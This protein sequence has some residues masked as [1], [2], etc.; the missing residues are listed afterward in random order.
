[1]SRWKPLRDGLDPLVVQFV[2]E[3]RRMK[4]ASGL[5]LT[6][7]A[8]K[9][10]RSA[11]SWERY[12]DSRVI[13]PLD[14]VEALAK[15][16]GA[17]PTRIT[18]LHRTAN[19]AWRAPDSSAGNAS[20]ASGTTKDPMRIPPASTHLAAEIR[21][22]R[23][24][25]GLSL[26]ALATETRYSKSSWARWLTGKA[27]PPWHAVHALCALAG[28]IDTDLRALWALA[29][30]EWSG[31]GVVAT[32][33]EPSTTAPPGSTVRPSELPADP[34]DFTGR[35]RE[36]ELIRRLLT[37]S[38]L[39]PEGPQEPEAPQEPQ[40]PQA[41]G[42]HAPALVAISGPGG[43]GKTALAVHAGHL[44]A[45]EFP[46]GELFADLRGAGQ[47]AAVPA[48]VLLGFLSS[49]G[50]PAGEVPPDGAGRSALF[51]S[52]SAGRRLLIVL[53]DVADAAQVRPL[54]P[55][56][57][58][59]AVLLTSRHKLP[60]LAG[61][62]H[63]DLDVLPADDAAALVARIAGR[64]QIRSESAAIRE[65]VAACGR[66]PLA[67]RIAGARLATR[68]SWTAGDLVE[69]LGTDRHR[70][71][72]LVAGD[73]GVRATFDLSYRGLP[74]PQARAFR[75]LSI[76]GLEEIAV[77]SAA[78]LLDLPDTAARRL[79][80]ALVDA[81]LLMPSAA[82]R[83]RY[84]DLIRLFAQEAAQTG[85]SGADRV[86]AL[87][88]LVTLY[89]GRLQSALALIRSG[90][91][92]GDPSQAVFTDANR[93]RHWLETE[94]RNI[95][96]TVVHALRQPELPPAESLAIIHA[97]QSF[98]RS[99]GFWDSSRRMSQAALERAVA[100]ADP[101]AELTARQYLGM[102]AVLT[103]D[104]AV[105]RA[106]LTQALHLARALHDRT[107]QAAALNRLGLLHFTRG[108]IDESIVS[109]QAALDIY[110]EL[111][112]RTGMCTTMIN[113]G[114]A[115]SEADRAAEALPLIEASLSL[116]SAAGDEMSVAFAEYNLARCYR[117]LRRYHE[118]IAVH[119]ASLPKLRESGLREGE[120]HTLA[121]LG[122]TL[123][124]A[125][126]PHEALTW[127]HDGIA[128]LR[129][130]GDRHSA[131]THEIAA[132]RAH[133][134]LG[135]EAEAVLVWTAALETLTITTPTDAAAVQQLIDESPL[136]G[137]GDR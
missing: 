11:S 86:S 31:R 110:R 117:R 114:K 53:D 94:V 10:G 64:P 37:S 6:Q 48:D 75:L 33:R 26:A 107:A 91:A 128:A 50:V 3:L 105:A 124:E 39:A 82:G 68:A 25:A 71:D 103:G 4:D 133:R 61:C 73:L 131:A 126:R 125:G 118:A 87:A 13:P 43:I 41:D 46:D 36:T 100:D 67:L 30:S 23:E 119:L 99:S 65:L 135:D 74:A 9:T 18:V 134:A 111:D 95:T 35:D 24:R 77:S 17:D 49:L 69:L 132:G 29:E 89:R 80:E 12:L 127:L 137:A 84:H 106:Q 60:D 57:G 120:A 40:A 112:D 14:V 72:E 22:L 102:I 2:V 27:V 108:E 90:Q 129:T 59:C 5:N 96:N 136:R 130:L 58:S 115:L 34:A 83:Y 7:L 104:P 70:L 28:G 47:A 45:R 62:Q 121:D 52:L 21:A 92:D 123:L 97:G 85:E 109:H 101:A 98:L 55:G 44:L 8:G 1:M 81:S 51:R 42:P 63:V 88:R 56:S 66:F 15:L 16:A 76:G 122:E 116:A 78:A 19:G 20:G 54:L 113:L 38:R 32:A 93:A 79:A